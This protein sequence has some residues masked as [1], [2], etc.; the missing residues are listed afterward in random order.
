PF[1]DAET[2]LLLRLSTSLSA[3]AL[4]A[5]TLASSSAVAA[6]ETFNLSDKAVVMLNR[7]GEVVRTTVAADKM[8]DD[9]LRI[10]DKRLVS[11]CRQ[12]ATRLERAI[13]RACTHPQ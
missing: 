13:G 2:G 1:C 3:N 9:D 8:F 5:E 6:L 7:L 10:R 12:S 11:A 4:L